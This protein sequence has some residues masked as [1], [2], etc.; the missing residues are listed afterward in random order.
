MYRRRDM[1]DFYRPEEDRGGGPLGALS[2]GFGSGTRRPGR[3]T[4]YFMPDQGMAAR[5]FFGFLG[6]GDAWRAWKT[7][8]NL[9]VDPQ[10]GRQYE[11]S[12][13]QRDFYFRIDDGGGRPSS[14]S[15]PLDS[16]L[17]PSPA[18]L[19]AETL[20]SSEPVSGDVAGAALTQSGGVGVPL[21]LAYQRLGIKPR[22]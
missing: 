12:P 16:V 19:A 15:G 1:S 18:T 6:G 9:P 22:F 7:T 20:S 11:L 10:T 14:P 5:P 4:R 21:P 17:Q 8:G 3:G 2:R 13:E